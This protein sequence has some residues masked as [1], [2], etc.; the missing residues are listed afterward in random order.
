MKPPRACA[1]SACWRNDD[2]E[3]RHGN[4]ADH[5]SGQRA[6]LALTL[7]LARRA[8]SD[9]PDLFLAGRPGERLTEITSL[10]RADGATA[11]AISCDL[12]RLADVHAAASAAKDLLATGA[13][14]PL[15]ALIANAG[16]STAPFSLASDEPVRL[17]RDR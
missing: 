10:V 15:R 1:T 6:G 4:R 8:E 16:V 3:H 7:E 17:G 2:D 12:A 14:R 13:A 11:E 5:G 9:R